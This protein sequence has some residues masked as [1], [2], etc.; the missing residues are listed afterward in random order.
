MDSERGMPVLAVET[1][2]S[3][4]DGWWSD[5]AVW[6]STSNLKN[7]RVRP[8]RF[9]VSCRDAIVDGEGLTSLFSLRRS[10]GRGS[11]RRFRGLVDSSVA[12]PS[13]FHS[14]RRTLTNTAVPGPVMWW[15]P[16]STPVENFT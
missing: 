7:D 15:V 12:V 6:V 13:H 11:E 4:E 10:E 14:P 5:A 8:H 3:T 9:G 1:Y 2:T 16:A